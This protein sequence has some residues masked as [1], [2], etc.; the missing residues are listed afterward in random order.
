M[1]I[2]QLLPVFEVT[3]KMSDQSVFSLVEFI[4]T[5]IYESYLPDVLEEKVSKSMFDYEVEKYL[6]KDE[7]KNLD[8]EIKN[9]SKMSKDLAAELGHKQ[10]SIIALETLIKQ[11]R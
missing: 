7:A 2:K 1:Q 4:W 3:N 8:Q 6:T 5:K 11:N 9:L 10:R